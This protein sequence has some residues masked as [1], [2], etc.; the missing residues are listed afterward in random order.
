MLWRLL[1]IPI[2]LSPVA[3]GRGEN[4]HISIA[5]VE[6]GCVHRW[7]CLYPAYLNSRKTLSEGRR[8]SRA[9]AVDNP[10]CT[11]IRDVCLSQNLE[12]EFESNK[13]YP[14]E[15]AK[16]QIHSGRVRVQIKKEDGSPLNKNI[17]SRKYT[18]MTAPM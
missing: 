9:K 5:P 1:Q 10:L 7:I 15:P 8:L 2:L 13:H 12:V 18:Q 6:T 14:R 16:D 3:T 17:T 11:E 4:L